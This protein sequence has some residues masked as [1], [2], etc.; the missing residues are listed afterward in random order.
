MKTAD[1]LLTMAWVTLT[2]NPPRQDTKLFREE[3]KAYLEAE[4]PKPVAW[5]LRP[6]PRVEIDEGMWHFH[7]DLEAVE[8]M[9]DEKGWTVEPLYANIGE[10][11]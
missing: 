3:L 9:R 6:P 4:K 2:I 1:E 7:D 10:K 5:R 11:E 8:K